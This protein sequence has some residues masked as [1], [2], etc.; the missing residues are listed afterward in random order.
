MGGNTQAAL[1]K[2]AATAAL[3]P[4]SSSS[5]SFDANTNPSVRFGNAVAATAEEFG[6]RFGHY[7][8]RVVQSAAAQMLSS[9]QNC[10]DLQPGSSAARLPADCTTQGPVRTLSTHAQDIMSVRI[11]L[12]VKSKVADVCRVPHASGDAGPSYIG[13]RSP[14]IN[15]TELQR[16]AAPARPC[17]L[18]SLSHL[19]LGP[20]LQ[21]ARCRLMSVLQFW[22]S[23]PPLQNMV[24]W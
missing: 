11:I 2:G 19:E 24:P 17:W 21:T 1:R 23:M 7:G 14:Q 22:K 15:E 18:K 12:W 13:S 10:A 6:E 4:Q 8:R 9:V 3:F 16:G 5:G 20:S